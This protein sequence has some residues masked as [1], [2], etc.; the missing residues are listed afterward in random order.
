MIILDRFKVASDL[1]ALVEGGLGSFQNFIA[2]AILQSGQEKL[3]LDEL[4]SVINAFGFDLGL[5]GSAAMVVRTLV[6]A[7]GFVSVR[8]L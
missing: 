3:M 4:Q 1:N 2:D 8:R 7:A 5:R 6:M